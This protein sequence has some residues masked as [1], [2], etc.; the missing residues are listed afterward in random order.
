MIEKLGFPPGA[1]NPLRFLK[2]EPKDADIEK[3]KTYLSGDVSKSSAPQHIK[4]QHADST[5]NH[6]T[7]YNQDLH[8]FLQDASFT[9]FVYQL[10]ALSRALRNSDYYAVTTRVRIFTEIVSGWN[11]F[12]KVMFYLLKHY[13]CYLKA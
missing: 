4:D 10:R 5:Y 9:V 1:F 6:L 3:M 11:D 8:K 2:W 7:P 12:A 13:F